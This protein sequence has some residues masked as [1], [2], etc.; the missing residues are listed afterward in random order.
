MDPNQVYITK[1]TKYGIFQFVFFVITWAVWFWFVEQKKGNWDELRRKK[2]VAG[3][4]GGGGRS[5]AR[6]VCGVP[7]FCSYVHAAAQSALSLSLTSACHLSKALTPTGPVRH[8]LCVYWCQFTLLL[9]LL[10][11]VLVLVPPLQVEL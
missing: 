11:L 4:F 1:H 9:L 6:G 8:S 10:E 2:G 7:S 3:L 5:G